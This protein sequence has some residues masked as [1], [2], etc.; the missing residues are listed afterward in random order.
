[1]P[2]HERKDPMNRNRLLSAI[3]VLVAIQLACSIGGQPP[4][5][6]GKPIGSIQ[7][8]QGG[9]RAGPESALQDVSPSRDMYDNEAAQVYNQGKARL[10]YGYGITF[11]LYNDTST[12]GTRVSASGQVE[13]RLA[14]GGLTGHN[15]AGSRTE[16]QLPN[17]GSVVILG[18]TYFILYDPASSTAW[19][20]NFD[21]TVRYSVGGG[22]LQD[23][24][25]GTLV[26]FDQAK[27]VES[28]PDLRFTPEEFDKY[29]TDL[30]SPIAGMRALLKDKRAAQPPPSPPDG[31][32][33]ADGLEADVIQFAECRYGPGAD[34]L[35][36]TVFKGGEILRA[37]GRD[38]GGHWLQV[39][40]DRGPCWINAETAKVGGNVMN[41]PDAYLSSAGLPI[42]GT[43]KPIEIL[44]AFR[45]G[46]SVQVQ[47]AAQEVPKD[48]LQ[49]GLVEYIV[50][51]WTCVDGRPGFYALGTDG[52]SMQFRV[53]ESCGMR[54]HGDVIGQN[55]EGF[56]PPGEIFAP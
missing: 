16:V 15:A 50:E 28:L 26:A 43:F 7:Q 44:E 52:T 19:V 36:M 53:D 39:Q 54:W 22:P 29:A 21:G 5:T 48:L 46:D 37:V 27:V 12:V 56:S 33:S 41:L 8:L 10:D 13:T 30:D 34:Y 3:A 23:L 25:A 49:Q 9:V 18:T 32:R 42:S 55:R 4:D 2:W 6:A 40:S 1:M 51:V 47:W 38:A 11:T 17:G 31:Q 20:Y 14:A 24:P 35:Q 45:K